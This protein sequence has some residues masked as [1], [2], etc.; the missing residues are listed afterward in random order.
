MSAFFLTPAEAARCLGVS[1]DAV[2]YRVR[3]G[4]LRAIWITPRLCRVPMADV[5]LGS[6]LWPTGLPAAITA[7]QVAALLE[8]H[9]RTVH[10]LARSGVL[11]AHRRQGAW[12]FS[13]RQLREWAER[14]CD[15]GLNAVA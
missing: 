8:V 3:Y 7:E 14:R 10:R 9:H 5:L 11:P 2:L 13:S 6:P 4:Q 12:A 15:E 1:T